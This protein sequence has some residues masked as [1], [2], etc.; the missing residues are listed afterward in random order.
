MDMKIGPAK[1]PGVEKTIL[2]QPLKL[3]E[4][5]VNGDE[6]Q[7]RFCAGGLY[8]DK[9]LYR[10]TMRFSRSEMAELLATVR[11]IDPKWLLDLSPVCLEA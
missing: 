6:V 1:R 9:S 8:D 4:V 10:Y 7:L 11:R 5:D 2:R 3:I